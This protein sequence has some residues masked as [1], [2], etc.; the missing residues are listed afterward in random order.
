MWTI[1]QCLVDQVQTD[2]LGVPIDE[3]IEKLK[4][5]KND[6]ILSGNAAIM[7]LEYFNDKLDNNI[8]A[9]EKDIYPSSI[10]CALIALEYDKIEA[11]DAVP[12]YLR[13]SQAERLFKGNG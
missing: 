12:H 13:P 7:Y 1:L 10:T 11:K 5:Y 3:L 8:I 6:I 2:D 9:L 4:K